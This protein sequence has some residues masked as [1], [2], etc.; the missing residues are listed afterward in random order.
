MGPA[1]RM[2]DEL[3]DLDRELQQITQQI[4]NEDGITLQD[5]RR[6]LGKLRRREILQLEQLALRVQEVLG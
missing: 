6:R 4:D 2:L 5:V 3:A 1:A